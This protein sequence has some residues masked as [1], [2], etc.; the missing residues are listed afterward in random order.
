LH[1]HRE[2]N[3]PTC[4]C[5]A[6]AHNSVLA[7]TVLCRRDLPPH[8]NNISP[9]GPLI[10]MSSVLDTLRQRPCPYYRRI[11][12]RVA[13]CNT[14]GELYR[15]IVKLAGGRA[16]SFEDAWW[17]RDAQLWVQSGWRKVGEIGDV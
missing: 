5:L 15:S 11:G 1:L 2:I 14:M 8:A 7:K 3:L 4:T 10:F 16:V 6:L 17:D 13:R 12:V 9:I